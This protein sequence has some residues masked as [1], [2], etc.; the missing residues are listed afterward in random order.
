M[1]AEPYAKDRRLA[2]MSLIRRHIPDAT[3]YSALSS[4]TG[5]PATRIHYILSV[6]PD[7]K[8]LRT[9]MAANMARAHA[10]NPMVVQ[11]RVR[12]RALGLTIQ[13]V[14]DALGWKKDRLN[15]YELGRNKVSLDEAVAW[16]DSIGMRLELAGGVS[17]P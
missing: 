10:A 11:L 14:A 17:D 1:T 16:A 12:R 15:S 6:M 4:A 5:L 13:Q 3:S 7:E 9:A 2:D 8:A